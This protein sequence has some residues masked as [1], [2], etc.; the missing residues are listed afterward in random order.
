MFFEKENEE[1][2]QK[3]QAAAKEKEFQSVKAAKDQVAEVGPLT[4][5]L[6]VVTCNPNLY[7]NMSRTVS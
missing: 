2:V 5:V 6:S 4:P 7:A 3:N 1:E